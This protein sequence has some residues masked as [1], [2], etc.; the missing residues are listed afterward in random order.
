[1]KEVEKREVED[2]LG[3]EITDAQ[4]EEAH[5]YAKMKQAY[6]FSVEKRPVVLQHWYLVELTKEYV[7]NLAFSR[8]TVD[9]CERLN[10]MEKERQNI[11]PGTLPS[12]HIVTQANA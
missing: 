3:T 1:M 9:L 11:V 12:N 10:N 8:F 6:I 2:L 5:E 4:F 7:Q